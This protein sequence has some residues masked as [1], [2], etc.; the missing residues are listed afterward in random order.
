MLFGVLTLVL[1]E[2]ILLKLLSNVNYDCFI[3]LK[4]DYLCFE[5]NLGN[6]LLYYFE[7]CW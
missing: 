4:E 2:Y 5:I 7:F 1:I 3:E 6:I